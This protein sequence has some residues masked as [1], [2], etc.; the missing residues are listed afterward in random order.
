MEPRM[1]RNYEEQKRREKGEDER[2]A[3]DADGFALLLN[4]QHYVKK[5][6]ASSETTQATARRLGFC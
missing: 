6:E 4:S 2:G 5:N 3:G 1:F